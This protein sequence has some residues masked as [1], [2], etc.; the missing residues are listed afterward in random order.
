MIS[1]RSFVEAGAFAF[2]AGPGA[3]REMVERA[4]VP[5]QP[6]IL[7]SRA[8]YLSEAAIFDA[9]VRDLTAATSISISTATERLRLT[10]IVA[11]AGPKLDYF[12]SWMVAQCLADAGLMRWVSSELRDSASVKA[13]IDRVKRNPASIDTVPA[14]AALRSKL[15]AIAEHQRRIV[16]QLAYME[17][18]IAEM[19]EVLPA[20]TAKAG[21]AAECQKTWVIV[22][23]ILVAVVMV[24]IA[25]VV[26]VVTYGAS[27]LSQKFAGTGADLAHAALKSSNQRY[28]DCVR[29]A[30]TLPSDRRTRALAACQAR[31]LNEKSVYMV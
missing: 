21:E 3:L 12:H 10:N 16:Q 6:T 14:I 9:G 24:V 4:P 5:S 30:E 1:R 22:T 13:F 26:S 15:A 7:K 17:K 8:Q 11:T 2:I 25:T 19:E 18:M 28:L 31:W 27:E 29:A 20:V 23:A